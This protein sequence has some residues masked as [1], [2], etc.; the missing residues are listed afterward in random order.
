MASHYQLV[1]Q[2]ILDNFGDEIDAHLDRRVGAAQPEHIA[3]IV[4]IE[5]PVAYLDERHR[6]KQPDWTFEPRWS[7]NSPADRLST[8]GGALPD[9]D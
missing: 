4:K 5:G 2:S 3:S 1:L 9:L 8:V 7:G 6:A